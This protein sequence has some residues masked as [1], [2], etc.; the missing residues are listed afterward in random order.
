[1]NYIENLEIGGFNFIHRENP[2]DLP[3]EILKRYQN[4]PED[5]LIFLKQFELIATD[6]DTTWFNSIEDFNGE[7]GNVFTW[8]DFE[9]QS[10]EIYNTGEKESENA[11]EFWNNHLPI[12]LSVKSEYQYL[13]IC[14]ENDRHGEIV[15]GLE[16][17]FEKV[18]KVCDNFEQLMVLIRNPLSNETLKYF[19]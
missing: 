1:M 14:L 4:I 10:L 11:R 2:R 19:V 3:A 16:P 13:A 6:D 7:S 12:V 18:T 15:Y 17:Q 8:N 9:L 5:Y